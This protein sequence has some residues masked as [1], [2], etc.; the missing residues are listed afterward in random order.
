MAKQLRHLALFIMNLSPVLDLFQRLI[1]VNPAA[2]GYLVI[3]TGTSKMVWL[4]TET[5]CLNHANPLGWYDWRN[6]V[7]FVSFVHLASCIVEGLL[8]NYFVHVSRTTNRYFSN[9]QK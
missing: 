8:V 6:V 4:D 1:T 9:K 2:K 5:V 3:W 7:T